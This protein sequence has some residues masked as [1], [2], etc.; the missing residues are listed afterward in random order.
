MN[1]IRS[2]EE[3]V[4]LVRDGDTITWSGCIGIL[5]PERVLGALEAKFLTEG[6][7]R[8]LT[9]FEPCS[10]VVSVGMEHFAYEGFIRRLITAHLGIDLEPD[11]CRMVVDNKIEAFA[12]PLGVAN[13]LL[14]EIARKSPGLLTKVGLH[15]YLDPRLQG[16]KYNDVTKGDLIRVVE[17]EGEE[18]LFLKS[19]PIN[20][21]VI[22]GTTAD[23]DG[24]LSLEEE[25]LTLSVLYQAMAASNWGGKVIA[26]VKR[27]VPRGSLDPRMVVVPGVMVDAVVVVEDQWQHERF[28]GEYDPG[29]DGRAR[30]APPPAPLYPL[31]AEKVVARRA[32]MELAAGQVVNLGAGIPTRRLAVFTLEEDI[33]DLITVSREHGALGGISYGRDVHVNPTSWLCYQD[34]FNWYTGGGLDISFSGFGQVNPDGDVNL[35]RFSKH[36]LRGPGG[37]ADIIHH[38]K[39]VVFTGA[40]TQGGLRVKIDRDKRC[41][42]IVEEGRNL[43]FVNRLY[44]VTMSGKYLG[45]QHKPVLF[46]TERAVFQLTQGGLELIE[47]APGIDLQKDV[48]EKMEFRPLISGS[49][50]E[51]DSRVFSD[52]KMGLRRDM[53]GCEEPGRKPP[54]PLVPVEKL[55][56]R[57][58]WTSRTIKR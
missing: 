26:Q 57:S 44:H 33:Q 28:P 50:R 40:F 53:L 54:V 2:L 51:M 1:K 17:F 18:W 5:N 16:G 23:E 11:H 6:H 56:E 9:L 13:Q 58:Y 42:V 24:N 41:M 48:L 47:I 32:A 25:P 12:I 38:A 37:A 7:P 14:A 22:R 3:V 4:E 15:S 43:K 45:S 35:T 27:V 46:V 29:I 8:D 39:K 19:F 21:A 49:L 10:T 36:V 52:G 31:D 20:V 34:V 30:V 55:P